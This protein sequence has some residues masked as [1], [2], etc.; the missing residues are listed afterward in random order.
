[1]SVDVETRSKELSSLPK[2]E[3]LVRIR[4]KVRIQIES[5]SPH[6]FHCINLFRAKSVVLQGKQ[7]RQRLCVKLSRG[8]EGDLW[9]HRSESIRRKRPEKWK[10]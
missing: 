1:M 10:T 4:V 5:Q 2:V 7:E 8:Q 9:S 6:S 3:Y